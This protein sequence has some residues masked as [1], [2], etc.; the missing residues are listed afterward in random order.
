MF[1]L[2]IPAVKAGQVI[3]NDAIQ[4]QAEKM[5]IQF[6]NGQVNAGMSFPLGVEVVHP[7]DLIRAYG[8]LGDKGRLAD[9]TTI[10]AVADSDGTLVDETTRAKPRRCSTRAP[11]TSPRTSWPATP[12]PRRTRSGASSRS[13]TAAG[14]GRRRSRPAP[15]TRLATSTPTATSGRPTTRAAR[16]A[17]SRSPSAPGTG[18]RTTRWSARARPAVLDRGHD[19]RLAGVPRGGDQGLVDQRVRG[20]ADTI[21]RASV[22]PWTGLAAGPRGPSVEE[23]FIVGT[24]PGAVL[25]PDAPVRRGDPQQRG[26]RGRARRVAGRGPRLADPRRARP[27]HARRAGG[28]AD[29]LLLQRPVHAVRQVVGR[30]GRR[31]GLRGAEPEPVGVVRSVR[32]SRSSRP[33]RRP[34]RRC[35]SPCPSPSRAPA[36]R[37]ADGPAHRGADPGADSGADGTAH[38][39]ADPEPT[40]SRPWSPP[41]PSGA[42]PGRNGRRSEPP[43]VSAPSRIPAYDPP[44]REPVRG[45]GR[46]T[47]DLSP[48]S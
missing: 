1:S 26:L 46:T 37:G 47:V 21:D 6:Q 8:V 7:L 12:T 41:R 24:R 16:T 3:G 20:G 14:A 29:R 32:P 40:P 38:A 13:R 25:S 15:A 43:P 48:R 31:R 36:D 10:I 44:G 33:T 39:R 28:H 4:A 9:Q 17:S 5:G 34:C 11:R 18:T 30:P 2:N 45:T 27:R 23:L 42:E 22:D 19:L 35:S